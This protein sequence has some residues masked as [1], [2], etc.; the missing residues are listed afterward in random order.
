[1]TEIGKIVRVRD[2]DATVRFFRRDECD[3]CG[4]CKVANDCAYV[5]ITLENTLNLNAEDYVRVEIY[6]K[7][8]YLSSILI[9][10]LPLCLTALCA[11]LGTL[12]SGAASA[13]L[14]F[15]GLIAGLAFALP[16]DIC[17]LR[18]R[19]GY[20]PR[21]TE[22]VREVDYENSKPAREKQ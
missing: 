7:R 8:A 16:I 1:M 9:Y 12:A 14:A 20:K 11:G 2:K 10:L 21:M 6:S 3:K 4:I 22:A 13:I 19:S 5:E 17:V 15:T 18:K